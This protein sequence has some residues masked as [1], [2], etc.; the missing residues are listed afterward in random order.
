MSATR[1][2]GLAGPELFDPV[3]YGRRGYPHETFRRLRH[4]DPVHWYEGYAPLP[5]WALT[6]RAEIVEVARQ[7]ERFSSVP[8]F[9]IVAGADYGED[10][11]EVRVITQMDPPEHG[12]R[13]ALASRRFTPRALRPLEPAV[14]AVTRRVLDDLEARGS[15]GECDFVEAIAAPLAIGVIARLMDL[16]EADW[17]R[18]YRWTNEMTGPAD[19]DQRRPGETPQDT[20]LRATEAVFDYFGGIVEARR[21]AGGDDLVSHLARARVDG[22]PLDRHELLSYYLLLVAG[23]NETT[24][25]ALSGGL[26]ALFEHPEQW[27]RLAADPALVVP[28]CE[29]ILR[30][31]TPVIHNART[32]VA[33]VELAGVR[34]REGDTLVLFWPSANRDE[35][36]FEAPDAF[37][38]DRHPNPHIAFG[39]G[40]HHCLGA[41]LARMELRCALRGLVARLDRLEPA[42]PAERLA[43]S[44]VGGVKRLPVRYRFRNG[45]T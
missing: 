16:P 9:H 31:T 32:A 39:I 11:R 43:S 8:R 27:R 7:P 24:R 10:P 3:A 13:R 1:P 42:G 41:H 4:A 23:G 36:V 26:L 22:E 28:A 18:L 30:W 12:A 40:E 34:I 38:I 45:R 20:R 15:A 21:E 29:E 2:E 6:R 35:A 5:F 17:P 33:D 44:S 14:E 37:R 25:N 19:P